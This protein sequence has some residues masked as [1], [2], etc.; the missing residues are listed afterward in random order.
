M[1]NEPH[2]VKNDAKH[3]N[4][5]MHVVYFHNAKV[6]HCFNELFSYFFNNCCL[7]S[8]LAVP[9]LSLFKPLLNLE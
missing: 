6:N 5:S 1:S 3:V 2:I 4:K 7:Y 9:G 8:L